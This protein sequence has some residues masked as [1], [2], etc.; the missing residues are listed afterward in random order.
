MLSLRLNHQTNQFN[1][2]LDELFVGVA[3]IRSVGSLRFAW[4]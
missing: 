1:L 2:G 3:R 4:G